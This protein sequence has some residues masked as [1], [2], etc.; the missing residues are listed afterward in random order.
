MILL[1][2]T[3]DAASALITAWGAVITLALGTILTI[4]AKFGPSIL[5]DLAAAKTQIDAL[6][7]TA[8]THSMQIAASTEAIHEVALKTP[9]QPIPLALHTALLSTAEQVNV[10]NQPTKVP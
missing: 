2:I 7:T 10:G 9:V 8:A 4:A 1:A 3:P 5:S 6:K